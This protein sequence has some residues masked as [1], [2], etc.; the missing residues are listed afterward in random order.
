MLTITNWKSVHF[1]AIIEK[2]TL[3]IK[4]FQGFICLFYRKAVP[5]Q[6]EK[7]GCSLLDAPSHVYYLINI[8]KA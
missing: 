8:K 6:T 4:D 1:C 3:K 2:L 5:L 7:K